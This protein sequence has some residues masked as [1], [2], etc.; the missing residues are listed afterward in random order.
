M[1]TTTHTPINHDSISALDVQLH[2]RQCAD[3]FDNVHV[4]VNTKNGAIHD[5]IRADYVT[6]TRFIERMEDMFT[7]FSVEITPRMQ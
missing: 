1:A 4:T 3:R 5:I 6:F 7:T 2:L